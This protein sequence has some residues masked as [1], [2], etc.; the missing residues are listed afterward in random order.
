MGEFELR[1][2]QRWVKEPAARVTS[3]FV[4]TSY[5]SGYIDSW[6]RA[7]A[8]IARATDTRDEL[9]EAITACSQRKVFA[10]ENVMSAVKSKTLL[11]D[12]TFIDW[13][14]GYAI[15]RC[16]ELRAVYAAQY[17]AGFVRSSIRQQ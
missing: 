13:F 17:D 16:S 8:Q 3:E 10:P 15:S 11:L 2:W 9:L 5:V 7:E 1:E 6:I 14:D 12:E 4:L